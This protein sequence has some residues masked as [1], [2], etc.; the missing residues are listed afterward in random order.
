MLRD[1]LRALRRAPGFTAIAIACLA[2]GLGA[3]TALFSVLNALVLR[4]LPFH[5][6]ERL[7]DV[8]E[9]NPAEL[10][11]GCS[12]GTALPT[13]EAWRGLASFT[14]MEA[15]QE[16]P[17]SVVAEGEAERSSGALVTAGLLDLLGVPPELGRTFRAEDDRVG[18]APVV[19]LSHRYWMSRFGGDPGVLDR[20]LRINGVPHSV[21]GVMP[22]RFGFPEFARFWVPMAGRLARQPVS[23][24][25]LGVV[26]RLVPG[27][28]RAAAQAELDTRSAALAAERP[29][30]YAGWVGR[31]SPL[32]RPLA[33]T[34]ANS[35]I[36]VGLAAAGFVLLITCANLATLLLA[37]GAARRR[38]FAV[39]AA[40]GA[41]RATL[42]RAQLGESLLMAAA[43]G[44]LG[45]V[46]GLW[47]VRGLLLVIGA[48]LPVWIDLSFDWRVFAFVA[49]V[50]GMTG[51]VFGLA[52]A[53]DAGR[54]DVQATLRGGA[55][56]G[57][58][59]GEGLLRDGLVVA[60]VTLA[61]ALLTGTGLA[62]RSYLTVS[63]TDNLGTDPA[64]VL[65][66][67]LRL[68]EPR[69]DDPAQVRG[70]GL[71]LVARLERLPGVEV[72]TV[73]HTEFLGSFV[74]SAS[75]VSLPG[76]PDPLPMHEAP[77][78]AAAVTPGHF[79][80]TGV[81]LLRGRGFT[82]A[83]GPGAPR[84]AVVNE[85]TAARL[86]PGEDPLGQRFLL[87]GEPAR[88][89]EVVGLAADVIG[90][91]GRSAVQLLYVPFAQD[92]GRPFTVEIRTAGP[93]RALAGALLRAV[94]ELDPDQPVDH[95]LTGTE[96]LAISTAPVRFM[97]TLLGGLGALALALAAFGLY[98]VLAYLVAR[99]TR[100][101]GI[102]LALGAV[103]GDLVRM[104]LGRA[105]RLVAIGL[106]LGLPLALATGR[107]VRAVLFG[108]TPSDPLVLVLVPILLA[109]VA[110]GAAWMPARRATRVEPVQALRTD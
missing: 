54:T 40:L 81:R 4:P 64:R 11:A 20:I 17:F 14:G 78:F 35:G 9:D 74:G 89:Y 46:V 92:P 56:S 32:E 63:R 28:S 42:I 12:V 19:V 6:V 82:A 109:L 52:P 53:L 107:I 37:R 110:A 104:V 5:E 60:Q 103:P 66:G 86:W 77:R 98:S 79:A 80:A 47:T 71:D 15:Y 100:E 102:R 67:D 50:A 97:A 90:N 8:H 94:R 7:V 41:S 25:S 24:R 21:V 95:L 72:A 2:L 13:M 84:V 101:L 58:T 75:R 51:V 106:V 76:R 26:A 29:A 43:G 55:G 27:V 87:A 1:A 18:A 93:P 22:A 69:Y 49:L 38:E 65:R 3:N 73:S 62:L 30:D 59:R 39:R 34:G 99:R 48:E 33:D 83:D 88:E 91:L 57:G 108:V 16:L 61:L 105:A 23:D 85:A 31:V 45:L 96:F 70:F 68:L 36:A 44:A 10:C